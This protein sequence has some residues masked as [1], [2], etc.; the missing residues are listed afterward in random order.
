VTLAFCW[1]HWRRY[2]FEI[3]K[4]GP[5]PIAHVALERIAALYKAVHK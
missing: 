2:F 5:A 1:L 4:G 3:D